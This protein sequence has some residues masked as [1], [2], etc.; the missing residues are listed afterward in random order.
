MKLKI[1]LRDEILIDNIL[2]A[3]SFW[4]RLIGLM[5][6]A[7]PPMNA[8]G[9]LIEPCNS[10]HTCFMK[11][12]LDIVFLD[13]ENKIVKVIYNLSPWRFTWLYFRAKKTLEVPSGKIRKDLT[14][15]DSL[16]VVYV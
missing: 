12:S 9:L 15:G 2:V 16:E 6:R 11:Y 5:F 8:N 1:K 3:R 10:I 7:K 4:D 14:P 13:N